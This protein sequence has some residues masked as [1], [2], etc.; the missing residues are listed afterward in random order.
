MCL[1][2]SFTKGILASACNCSK[3][4]SL[5]KE[6]IV[7]DC[8]FSLIIGTKGNQHNLQNSSP[9]EVKKSNKKKMITKNFQ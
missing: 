7:R 4:Q 5:V 6:L 8:S 3:T 2:I 1:V 9:T